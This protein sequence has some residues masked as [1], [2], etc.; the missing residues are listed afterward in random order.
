MTQG[1]FEHVETWLFDLDNT[2][3]PSSCDLFAQ[4]DARMTSYITRLLDL[5][6][7]EARRLQKHYYREHGTTLS[8][9][10][11]RH[12]V[13]PRD[14]LAFVHDIDVSVVPPNPALDEALAR[15]PGRKVIFTNGSVSHAQNVVDRL[16]ITQHFSAIFDIEAA[17]YLP[18]PA[19]A[20]YARLID[21]TAT[22][23]R[24][25]AM[26]DDIALN[27]KAAHA[28]GMTTVWIRTMR[29]Y[30]P[31]GEPHEGDHIHHAAD[32]L[33]LFLTERVAPLWT[34]R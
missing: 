19:P 16:G 30:S 32:D 17:G 12:R 25:A 2:L 6:A 24:A 15:L 7:E 5:P 4:I 28:L 3:Y 9:L 23:P 14:Y 22:R 21:A 33:T 1:R 10:M 34:S 27:L 29:D 20:T 18:K 13:D 26:F 31:G 8:G 11:A